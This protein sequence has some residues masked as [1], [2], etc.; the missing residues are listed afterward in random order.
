VVAPGDPQLVCALLHT[1]VGS[2]AA[3]LE[4]AP[5]T[6]LRLVQVLGAGERAQVVAGWNDTAC[7]VPGG[8]L[9]GLLEE[10]AARTP[11]AVAVACDA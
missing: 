3:A 5:A 8:T 4:H 10:Q 6:P 7:Q 2:L 1:A 11:D 9:P